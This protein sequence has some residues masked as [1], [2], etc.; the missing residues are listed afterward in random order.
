M[1]NKSLIVF[2]EIKRSNS[3]IGEFWSARELAKALKYTNF[4]NFISVIKKAKESCKNAGQS[5]KNHFVDVDDMVEIGSNASRDVPDTRLSRYACYLVMQNADPSKEIVALGQ[6]YFAIQ[7][8]KQELQ[9]QQMEDH[10]RLTL[11]GE[12][13]VRNK[14]L[15]EAA[16][17]AGVENFG[18]FTNYGYRGLYGGLDVQAIHKMKK[19]K[20]N[21]KILDHMGGEELG[22]NIFR[23]TQATAKIKRENIQGEARAN[24]AHFHVGKE[25]RLT[26]K[27]LGGTVPEK[28]PVVDSIKKVKGRVLIDG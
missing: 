14:H 3:K 20:K 21:Q 19:L 26:I 27:H 24:Q 22:A 8:R 2:E 10:T 9:D 6:T 16:T 13:T 25:V 11:R 1:P 18:V 12:I 15:A 17:V 7:T 23:A 4:R 5:I 28:L